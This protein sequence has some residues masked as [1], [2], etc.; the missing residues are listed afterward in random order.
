MF[1]KLMSMWDRYGL[2]V[3]RDVSSSYPV[4]Q[5]TNVGI[6][7]TYIYSG[8]TIIEGE[9]SWGKFGY[10]YELGLY[11]LIS[12]EIPDKYKDQVKPVLGE[13][14]IYPHHVVIRAA[15]REFEADIR[16]D[17]VYPTEW[18]SSHLYDIQ[19]KLVQAEIPVVIWSVSFAQNVDWEQA[20]VDKPL[21]IETEH[22]SIVGSAVVY[23]PQHSVLVAAQIMPESKEVLTALRATLAHNGNKDW[24][25][26]RGKNTA[27]LRGAKIGYVTIGAN[28]S[29]ENALGGVVVL[30][31]P[32]TGDP[33]LV[34][35]DHFYVV[36]TKDEKLVDKFTDRL[37]LAI[38]W[39][40]QPEW[41]EY[42]LEKGER[43]GLTSKLRIEGD[44]FKEAIRVEIDE[45]RW[46][47]A[48]V[49]GIKNDA[50]V[51]GG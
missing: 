42:L 21:R 26:V 34:K 33:Q 24:V 41:G 38:S 31:H 7:S 16:L 4:L 15:G 19:K 5:N 40:I 43:A 13:A 28:M 23:D 29:K 18:A 48:I 36:T 50:I 30:L 9:T 6:K 22:V 35:K 44:E 14:V 45:A 20:N 39:P 25:T 46:E 49:S 3:A 47:A 8:R 37:Q 17:N 10:D 11:Y 2:F 32:L 51:I 12:G 27:Y 1:E